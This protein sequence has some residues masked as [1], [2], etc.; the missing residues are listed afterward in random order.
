MHLPVLPET[1]DM[2]DEDFIHA[3][4]PGS[5]LVNT[6]RGELIVEEALIMGLQSGH[7]RGAALDA[8]TMEPPDLDNPL[9]AIP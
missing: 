8:F 5:F 1:T 9:I 3:M 7:L 6:A 4:K 2:V